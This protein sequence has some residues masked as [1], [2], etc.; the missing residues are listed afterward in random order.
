M[1]TKPTRPHSVVV[2]KLPQSETVV[3]VCEDGSAAYLKW[4][5]QTWGR[6]R[7]VPGTEADLAGT[8]PRPL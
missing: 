4:E 3:V 6:L 8:E 2:V 7:A 1:P 5:D